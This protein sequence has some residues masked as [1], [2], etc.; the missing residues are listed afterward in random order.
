[1]NI[2]SLISIGAMAALLVGCG[3]DDGITVNNPGGG[4]GGGGGGA[5]SDAACEAVGSVPGCLD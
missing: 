5:L 4:S 3:D 1:M 2:K